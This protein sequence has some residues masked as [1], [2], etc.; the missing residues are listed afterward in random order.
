MKGKLNALYLSMKM[1]DST[2]DMEIIKNKNFEKLRKELEE[3]IARMKQLLVLQDG[4]INK[5][6]DDLENNSNDLKERREKVK[7]KN[8]FMGEEIKDLKDEIKKRKDETEIA[9]NLKNNKQIHY[10]KIILGLHLIKK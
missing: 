4:K 10:I 9:K 8:H 7:E 3:E 1:L 2:G 5:L 6:S